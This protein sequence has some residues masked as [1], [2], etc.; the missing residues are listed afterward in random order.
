MNSVAETIYNQ[1]GANKFV[2]MVGAKMWEVL[3]T[4]VRFRIGSTKDTS[5]NMVSIQLNHKDLYDI[6]FLHYIP[7]KFNMNTLVYRPE[8]LD[9]IE[10]VTDIYAEQLQSIFTKH[11]GLLTHL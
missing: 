11:T 1:L 8:K 5:I 3:P 7:E 9:L 2:A 4:G 10:D 6:Q